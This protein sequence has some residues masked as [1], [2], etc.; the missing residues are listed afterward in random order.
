MIL[1]CYDVDPCTLSLWSQL[2]HPPKIV[3]IIVTVA[4]LLS[5]PPLAMKL[6][7]SGKVDNHHPTTE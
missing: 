5:N 7:T 1:H 3:G 2:N 6:V 4:N